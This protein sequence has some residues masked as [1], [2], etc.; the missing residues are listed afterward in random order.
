MKAI[1]IISPINT[2]TGE[3]IPAGAIVL[4]SNAYSNIDA[5]KDNLIPCQIPCKVYASEQFYLDGKEPLYNIA[6]FNASFGDLMATSEQF[7]PIR[8]FLLAVV[9][10]RLVSIYGNE[11]VEIITI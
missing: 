5:E 1:K 2:T 6:D 9:E 10:A 4:L 8:Q 3:P 7:E 11:N